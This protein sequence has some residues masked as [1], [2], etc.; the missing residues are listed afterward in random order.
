MLKCGK[1]LLMWRFLHTDRVWAIGLR[2]LAEPIEIKYH[3]RSYGNPTAIVPSKMCKKWQWATCMIFCFCFVYSNVCESGQYTNPLI[4]NRWRISNELTL[5]SDSRGVPID[6]VL[7]FRI[8]HP[9]LTLFYN[10]LWK[11]VWSIWKTVLTKC[12]RFRVD[13]AGAFGGNV[14][15]RVWMN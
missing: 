7:A 12:L 5:L 14:P 11:M 9:L 15:C 13:L 8:C 2:K 3:S 6:R 4:G 1:W 10:Q